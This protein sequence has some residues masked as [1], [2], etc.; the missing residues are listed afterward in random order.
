MRKISLTEIDE[1]IR[2]N[3]KWANNS[4]RKEMTSSSR[5]KKSRT[6]TQSEVIALN[7]NCCNTVE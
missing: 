5:R 6:R 7:G 3:R 1:T 2:E 4:I